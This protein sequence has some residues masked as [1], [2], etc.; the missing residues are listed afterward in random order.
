MNIFSDRDYEVSS[1]VLWHDGAV[2]HTWL[3]DGVYPSVDGRVTL[4][5]ITEGY[6]VIYED[7]TVW[8]TEH[9]PIEEDGDLKLKEG[10][11][12]CTLPRQPVTQCFHFGLFVKAA[13]EWN[14]LIRAYAEACGLT[15][16]KAL[17]EV[18]CSVPHMQQLQKCFMARGKLLALVERRPTLEERVI[19]INWELPPVAAIAIG[20]DRRGMLHA[21]YQKN[22]SWSAVE[23]VEVNELWLIV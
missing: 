2:Y 9:E 13:Q 23:L 19:A 18:G 11:Y 20:R 16:R 14:C 22:A 10:R 5:A 8:T 15:Y 4:P 12:R 17:A 6:E 7:G 21:Q 1:G 3:P